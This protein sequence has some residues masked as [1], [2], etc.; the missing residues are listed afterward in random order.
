M[1]GLGSN[2]EESVG[3]QNQ[4]QF[5]NLERMR[6][7]EVSV[8]TTHTSRNHSR[9]G[10]HVSHGENTRNMQ[11]EIDH[12]RRK[13]RRKQR[14]GTPLSS[15]SHSDDGD[16]SYRPRSRTPTNE[17]FSRDED[18]HHRRRSRSLSRRG[19]GNDAMSRVLR[20]IS[21]SPFTQRIE[22]GKLPQ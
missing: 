2:Y 22:G 20:Q 10:S 17:S 9:I 16:G 11:L 14:R 3:S 19:L 1:V 12:L 15:E 5:L 7:R 21:K 6:D 8:H 18:R 4:D 13:L